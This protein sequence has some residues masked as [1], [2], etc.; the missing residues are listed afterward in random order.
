MLRG[1]E[2]F[3]ICGLC[4]FFRKGMHAWHIKKVPLTLIFMHQIKS[5]GLNLFRR[6]QIDGARIVH[7]YIN[8]AKGIHRGLYN[9]ADLSSNR[10][11][12][13]RGR[14]FPDR[15]LQFPPQPYK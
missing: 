1:G 11:S 15:L 6:R 5:L 3:R 7:Q 10:I 2:R 14:L 12:P 4:A 13:C 9:L 8:P